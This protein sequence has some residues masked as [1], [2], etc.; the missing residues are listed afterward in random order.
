MQANI[1][2]VIM[3]RPGLQYLVTATDEKKID[4]LTNGGM[5]RLKEK[6]SLDLFPPHDYL[7]S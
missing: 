4:L 5:Q 6:K 3:V 1:Q 7:T 2:P